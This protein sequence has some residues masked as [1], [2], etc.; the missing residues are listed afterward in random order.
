MPYNCALAV[1]TTFCHDI[2]PALIPLFGPTF[3][4]LCVPPEA[5]EYN[6]W[7]IDPTL[8]TTA[9][10]LAETYRL[11]SSLSLPKTSIS[12]SPSPSPFPHPRTKLPAAGPLRR[13]RLKRGFASVEDTDTEEG[14]GEGSETSGGDASYFCSPG[15]VYAAVARNM[16]AHAANSFNVAPYFHPSSKLPAHNPNPWLS[17]IP[18]STG[19]PASLPTSLP[20]EIPRLGGYKRPIEESQGMGAGGGDEEYDGEESASMSVSENDGDGK[21]EGDRDVMMEEG[22]SGAEKKA[23]WLLMKLSVR[24][25]AGEAS[26]GEGPRVKRRR[27]T[28]F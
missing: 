6:R 23:A 1:C 28:S 16:A 11:S 14:E 4:S 12:A 20:L 18:R 22:V 13:M 7:T 15:P 17:A 2:A 26:E 21:G 19:L 27:A 25:G 24:D 8:I 10:A 9:T 5:P 3:P